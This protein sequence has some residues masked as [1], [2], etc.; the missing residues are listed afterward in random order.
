MKHSVVKDFSGMLRMN[1]KHE[2][3]LINTPK[4]KHIF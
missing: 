2:T 1:Q 3:A 4:N